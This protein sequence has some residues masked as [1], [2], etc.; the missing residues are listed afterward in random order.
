MIGLN[1]AVPAA[2]LCIAR[3]LYHISSLESVTVTT[4][5]KRRH[6]V[7]DLLIGLGL[8]V[9]EMVLRTSRY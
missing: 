4:A 6:V 3:R 5:V 1:V 8:P 2:G 7:V 9:L